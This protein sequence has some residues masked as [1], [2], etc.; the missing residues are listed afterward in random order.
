MTTEED[1]SRVEPG[2]SAVAAN[3]AQRLPLDWLAP[4]A[5]QPA[6][7]PLWQLEDFLILQQQQRLMNSSSVSNHDKMID[8][9]LAV[10]EFLY[11]RTITV[12]ALTLVD[13]CSS[14]M[15][16][17]VAPS[18]RT[19]HLIRGSKG[20]EVYLCMGGSPV[21]T[22][23]TS[24]ATSNCLSQV[25]YCSCR[26]FLE[27]ASKTSAAYVSIFSPTAS[28]TTTHTSKTTGSAGTPICKHLLALKLLPHLAARSHVAV[29]ITGTTT[30]MPSLVTYCPLIKAVSEE[31]FATLILD[32]ILGREQNNNSV[33]C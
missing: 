17:I 2:G 14:L 3:D 15:T 6:M 12:A 19:V 1:I 16:K 21:A 28:T 33:G 26:S 32:Q 25:H 29:P 4:N 23:S 7:N 24:T 18:G 30:T 27:K 8:D 11:G 20:N 13:S 9:L 10:V 22:H 31:E 5:P